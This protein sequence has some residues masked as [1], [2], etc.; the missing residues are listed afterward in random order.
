M[1]QLTS[2]VCAPDDQRASFTREIR[3]PAQDWHAHVRSRFAQ[4]VRVVTCFTNR[5]YV[6]RDI[7]IC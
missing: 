7:L 5:G 1:I 3:T 6:T 2:I 4:A